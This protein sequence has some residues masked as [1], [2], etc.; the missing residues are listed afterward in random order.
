MFCRTLT[1]VSKSFTPC[2]CVRVYDLS[3]P[4]SHLHSQRA[5]IY[6]TQSYCTH[7]LIPC[8]NSTQCKPCPSRTFADVKGLTRCKVCQAGTKYD[9]A[10]LVTATANPCAS[11][12]AGTYRDNI[13][14]E[15]EADNECKNC[16]LG[17]WS[18]SSSSTCMGCVP[19]KVA[20]QV[21]AFIYMYIES[22]CKSIYPCDTTREW[23]TVLLLY[24]LRFHRSYSLHR[25]RAGLCVPCRVF[26]SL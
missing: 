12:P 17:T 26:K 19:G 25:L 20:T 4:V 24:P 3:S 1:F 18:S 6:D 10:L 9:G 2:V 13:Q 21:G 14:V 8:H 7:F 15:T 11:C 23:L 22:E 5:L 16:S